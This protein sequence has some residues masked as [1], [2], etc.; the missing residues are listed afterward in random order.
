MTHIEP[1]PKVV[2]SIAQT[3][4]RRGLRQCRDVAVSAAVYDSS[5]VGL[6]EDVF[7]AYRD[8]VTA[9]YDRLAAALPKPGERPRIVCLCGS[10]RFRAEHD[11]ANREL[12]MAGYIVLGLGSFSHSDGHAVTDAEKAALDKLHFAKIDIAD[13]VFVINPGGY[14]G[15]STANEIAYATKTGKPVRYLVG[16]DA[17][18]ARDANGG[19]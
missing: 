12:T 15:T 6:S 11:A 3:A 4:M 5:V 19:E 1:D 17:F 18:A 14:I 7:N 9:E 16:L 13:E 8:A 2:Y 10:S